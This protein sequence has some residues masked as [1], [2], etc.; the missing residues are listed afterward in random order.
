VEILKVTPPDVKRQSICNRETRLVEHELM[1]LSH[2]PFSKY[3]QLLMLT[4]VE[5]YIEL[6]G[7]QLD[8]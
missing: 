3:V 5:E 6:S 2:M 4:K 8:Q 1:F 7:I